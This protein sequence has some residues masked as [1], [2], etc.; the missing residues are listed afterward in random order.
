M[1]G[2]TLFH[3]F[4]QQTCLACTLSVGRRT[5]HQTTVRDRQFCPGAV[6]RLLEEMN[7]ERDRDLPWGKGSEW[8]PEETQ[9]GE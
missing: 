8:G 6:R 9:R 5:G 1:G 2:P 3:P 4:I 7:Q